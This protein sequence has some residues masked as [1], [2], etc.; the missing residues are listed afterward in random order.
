MIS[1]V[2]T[3]LGGGNPVVRKPMPVAGPRRPNGPAGMNLRYASYMPSGASQ[4]PAGDIGER[5]QRESVAVG[6]FKDGETVRSSSVF[7]SFKGGTR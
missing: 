1:T 7:T 5:R 3:P 6:G 4:T 2:L